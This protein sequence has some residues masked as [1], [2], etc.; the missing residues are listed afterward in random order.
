[1]SQ[2]GWCV[3]K[4]AADT[5]LPATFC[6]TCIP[7]C[8]DMLGLSYKIP[9]GTTLCLLQ[10]QALQQAFQNTDFKAFTDQVLHCLG[11]ICATR[12]QAAGSHAPDSADRASHTHVCVHISNSMQYLIEFR[13]NVSLCSSRGSITSKLACVAGAGGHCHSLSPV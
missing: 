6:Q 3:G 10:M 13:R 11:T 5:T 8:A 4:V 7:K 12:L 2:S 1:M 9:C